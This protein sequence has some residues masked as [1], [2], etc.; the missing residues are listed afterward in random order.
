[1]GGDGSDMG[2]DKQ[3]WVWS[4]LASENHAYAYDLFWCDDAIYIEIPYIYQG[5]AKYEK[6]SPIL[7]QSRYLKGYREGC[8]RYV[9]GLLNVN[10]L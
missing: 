9:R 7:S 4:E 1:M 3:V 10:I 6:F 2:F 8:G 5:F